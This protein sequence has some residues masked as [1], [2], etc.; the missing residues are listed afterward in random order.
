M[1]LKIREGNL[2]DAELICELV[3]NLLY[4]LR[5]KPLN[6]DN[7][8]NIS[9]ELLK[10]KKQR[11]VAYLA[12]NGDKCLGVVTL[13]ECASLY[14]QGAFGII[15]ELYIIPSA[16]SQGIGNQLI[17]KVK[18]YGIQCGWDRIEVG[19][20]DAEKW[21]KTISFYKREGFRELGPRLR[22]NLI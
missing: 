2:E 16:R 9:K 4:E 17:K 15:Q 12:F 19:A 6:N 21:D 8:I 18:E 7:L 5:G 22:C 1:S 3:A 13:S 20:P 11:Y 10:N 14:A